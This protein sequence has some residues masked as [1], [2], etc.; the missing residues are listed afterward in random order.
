MKILLNYS[1]FNLCCQH[2]QSLNSV[3]Q[4]L[5]VLQ[6]LKD[7]FQMRPPEEVPGKVPNDPP[8]L[9]SQDGSNGCCDGC[10]E[11]RDSLGVV[12]IHPVLEVTPQI[13]I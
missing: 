10:L 3:Q 5:F 13:E 9:L 4:K 1:M 7:M 11:V 6:P 2:L 12:L 8:A